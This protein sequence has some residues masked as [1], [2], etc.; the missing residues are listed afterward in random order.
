MSFERR[1]KRIA[2]PGFHVNVRYDDA[3]VSQMRTSSSADS[4][5]KPARSNEVYDIKEMELL[6]AK[7]DTAMYYDGYTHCFSAVNGY[8]ATVNLSDIAIKNKILNEV[9]FVGVAVTEYKPSKAYS[10]QG[11]VSQIGGVVTL[12]NESKSVI[13]PGQKVKLGLE[14]S[15]NRH[16]T[17]DKGIP[18]EKVRFCIEPANDE[19]GTIVRSLA[20][21]GLKPSELNCGATPGLEVADLDALVNAAKAVNDKKTAAGAKK[22]AQAAIENF[23]N[24]LQ[25]SMNTARAA[26]DKYECE[27]IAKFLKA[28]RAENELIIGKALGLAKSGDRVEV[29][30]QP[31]HSY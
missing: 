9:R 29:L 23:R 13:Y 28:Y 3:T 24:N 4:K 31:R 12:I 17:R 22:T 10:E 5:L 19:I 6:V 16:I 1:P 7:K 11:F 21:S 8:P 20:N 25:T 2:G 30:L 14:M 27:N 15:L 26:G 18:R